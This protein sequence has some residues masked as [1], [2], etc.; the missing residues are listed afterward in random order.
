V[1]DVVHVVHVAEHASTQ[2][3]LAVKLSI[4]LMAGCAVLGEVQEQ[5]LARA[6]TPS[7]PLYMDLQQVIDAF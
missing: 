2:H 7:H 5:T 1:V 6:G 4:K 3:G